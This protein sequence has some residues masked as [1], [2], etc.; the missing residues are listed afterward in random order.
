MQKEVGYVC[1]CA[2]DCM[3]VCVFNRACNLLSPLL[4]VQTAQPSV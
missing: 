4:H 3:R 2:F 1:V